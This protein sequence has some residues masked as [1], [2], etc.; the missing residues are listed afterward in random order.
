M[1]FFALDMV[2]TTLIMIIWVASPKKTNPISPYT[3]NNFVGSK[4]TPHKATSNNLTSVKIVDET[5]LINVTFV[6]GIFN[7]LN[8]SWE[9]FL[10][11][12]LVLRVSVVVAQSTG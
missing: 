10:N 1:F 6:S 12:T 7:A 11:V 3:E 5:E 9:K 8:S 2:V 4:D